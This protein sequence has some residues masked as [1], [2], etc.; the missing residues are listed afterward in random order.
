MLI[1]HRELDVG[2]FHASL[3]VPL[4]QPQGGTHPFH[5]G[6]KRLCSAQIRFVIHEGSRQQRLHFG[7][8]SG[9]DRFFFTEGDK[10]LVAQ[11]RRL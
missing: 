3:D 9:I 4:H 7:G 6:A 2:E 11:Q 10:L 1:S 5:I 8:Q